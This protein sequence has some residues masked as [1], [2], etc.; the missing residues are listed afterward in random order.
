MVYEDDNYKIPEK[1]MKMS[2]AELEQ[3]AER[4]CLEHRKNNSST[5]T[6]TKKMT[7]DEYNKMFLVKK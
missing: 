3:E 5:K 1:Y 4:L 6:I 7:D 2:V